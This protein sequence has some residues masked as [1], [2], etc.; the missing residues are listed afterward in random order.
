MEE[1]NYF[2]D[3]SILITGG[4]GS[5][6]TYLV[7]YLL[8]TKCK[9]MRILSNNEHELYQLQ[10][11][12]N[13]T[14]MR[15][16]LGDVRDKERLKVATDGIDLVF[17]AAALKHVPI[18]E[19]NPLDAVHT[20]VIGTQ[21]I[22]EASNHSKV[23]KF[24]FIST[25]KAVSPMSTLGATKLLAERLTTSSSIYRSSKLPI[26]YCVRFGNVL[27]SRGSVFELFL[28]QIKTHYALTVT[29]K[30]IKR[31]TMTHDDY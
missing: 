9:T 21:N 28:K 7:E 6:G 25:D 20:N 31:F 12:F 13:D 22:I 18:C 17:H 19:Y 27:G 11:K 29:D 15:L 1:F 30:R 3:K 10:N 5:I 26:S 16:L 24:V 4:S 2:K 8:K 14:R 23:E